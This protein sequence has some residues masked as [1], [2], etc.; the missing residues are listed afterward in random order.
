MGSF[1]VQFSM[2]Q[3]N[4]AGEETKRMQYPLN[5]EGRVEKGEPINVKGSD[6]EAVYKLRKTFDKDSKEFVID[7]KAARAFVASIKD[8]PGD[9][10]V[11]AYEKAAVKAALAAASGKSVEITGENG[12]WYPLTATAAGAA[13][14]LENLKGLK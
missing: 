11:Y 9:Q 13:I 5:L 7:Q 12:H 8:N 3:L 6:P 2:R 1:S 10:Q 14:L 4:K